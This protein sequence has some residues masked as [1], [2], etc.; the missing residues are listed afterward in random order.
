MNAKRV[1]VHR[2]RMDELVE[3]LS[4][5]LERAVLGYGLD[6]GTTMGPLHPPAQK[7][8]VDGDHRGGQGSGAK[9]LEFG[10]LPGG[11]LAG[12]NFLRPA[13]VVDPDPRCGWSPRSSSGR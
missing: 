2:S 3:G 5:R 7:A 11:E 6:E 10:E 12:G 13:I 8:F 9:V 4:A 1:Y